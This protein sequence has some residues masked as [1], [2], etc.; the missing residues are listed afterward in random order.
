MARYIPKH[1]RK[2]KLRDHRRAT[3]IA[4]VLLAGVASLSGSFGY[5]PGALA[6]DPSKP[7]AE[8]VAAIH[9]QA[10]G[11]TVDQPAPIQPDPVAS[12]I[13]VAGSTK[14][15]YVN[16]PAIGVG[17]ELIELG[18]DGNGELEVPTDFN[19]AGWFRSG[20]IPGD[21]GPAVIAGHLDSIL[22]PAIFSKL[23]LLKPGDIVKILR[24]DSKVLAFS[25]TRID[26]FPKEYFP[27]DQV[28]GSTQTPE[29]RL[30]TCGGT[31]NQKVRS[32]TGNTVVYASLVA[33]QST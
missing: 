5:T 15:L 7:L 27:T 24:K 12:A 18:L 28:Y 6:V 31:F 33:D 26:N 8:Q 20:A 13:D 19:Q 23:S 21:V 3:G 10:G 14:P 2:Q 30:I 16:I 17:S 9:Q 1:M 11:G 29:L 22:G 4:A 25:V 32:Y